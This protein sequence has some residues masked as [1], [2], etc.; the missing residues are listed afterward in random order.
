MTI[1]RINICLAL[2]AVAWTCSC[3]RAQVKAGGE[4]SAVFD[5]HYRAWNTVLLTHV[6]PQGVD[7]ASLAASPA[8]L[9]EALAEMESVEPATFNGW[10]RADR[11]AFLINAH[12]AHA[13]A[14]IVRHY[15]AESLAETSRWL[16]ARWRCDIRLLGRHWSLASLADEIMGERYQD[17]RAIFLLNWA[18]QG[19]S[20]LPPVAVT[21][22]NYAYL[23]DRQTRLCLADASRQQYD[24]RRRIIHL[25]PLVKTYRKDLER[26]YTTLWGFLERFLPGEPAGQ[27]HNIR[28]R[29]RYLAFDR[30]L[31]QS[32][33]A[34]TQVEEPAN[35]ADV[36]A[37]QAETL[38]A[39]E[40]TDEALDILSRMEAVPIPLEPVKPTV[41]AAQ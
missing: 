22:R 15:P 27:I 30:S 25:T 31:N 9:D 4:P 21:G 34:Y 11:L 8:P 7:Y 10:Q 41:P 26:D 17:S 12:N 16:P 20:P 18:E 23:A 6:T 1:K 32:A 37:R 35:A 28:P 3:S 13:V 33:E 29:I 36:A 39:L 19:C 40:Q 14:R 2:L 24:S 38:K 5:P